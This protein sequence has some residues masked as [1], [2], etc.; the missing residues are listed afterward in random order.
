[1]TR[2]FVS[3]ACALALA[4]ATGA[5]P[6]PSKFEKDRQAILA[7]AGTYHV[8]FEFR[9]TV[10]L[11]PGYKPI[12]LKTS[13]GE[14]VVRVIED[15]GRTIKLQHILV[16]DI[17]GQPYITK[18]WRQDWTYEP[19]TVMTYLGQGRWTTRPVGAAERK[20][21]WSQTV[22]QTDDSPRYGGVG[23]WAFDNGSTRWMS[24]VSYRPLARRDAVRNPPYDRYIGTNRHTLTPEGWVHEQD[25]AKVGTKDGQSVTFVH[26]V[27][28]NTYRRGDD[29]NWRAADDYWAKTKDYWA[30]VRAAWDRQFATHKV[31]AVTEEA[32]M[33]SLTSPLLMGLADEIAEGKRT[34]AEAVKIA[35]PF[36]AS[37]D[38][39]R[40]RTLASLN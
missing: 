33:G 37:D 4:A 7:M 17:K 21:A 36:I 18:H 6:E 19:R 31:V 40:R 32:Q 14:E 28:L 23:K 39:A 12:P 11:T 27:A 15:T 3:F 38:A 22:W 9:E 10:A 1:M 16:A 24:D 20:G 34:T 5:A 30:Q 25:N 8:G 13:G 26:E 2:L 35:V 29:F